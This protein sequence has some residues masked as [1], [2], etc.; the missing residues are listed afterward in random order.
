MSVAGAGPT[1]DDDRPPGHVPGPRFTM[2]LLAP[3]PDDG[4]WH[5]FVLRAEGRGFV[6]ESVLPYRKLHLAVPAEEDLP[7]GPAELTISYPDAPPKVVRLI[8]PDGIRAG[9]RVVRGVKSV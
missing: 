9:D 7:G 1:S 6:L 3:R 2:S 8:L 4:N 5:R